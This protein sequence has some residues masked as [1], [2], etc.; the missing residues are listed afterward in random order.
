[1]MHARIATRT[2]VPIV[3]RSALCR[4]SG[5]THYLSPPLQAS[6][7]KE[8]RGSGALVSRCLPS[9]ILTGVLRWR[10]R[11][12]LARRGGW[13]AVGLTGL[14][15]LSGLRVLVGGGLIAALADRG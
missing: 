6:R 4:T 8:P 14:T 1:M 12:A 9:R 7:T 15:G 13:R 10:W 5:R 3:I 11:V 2:F